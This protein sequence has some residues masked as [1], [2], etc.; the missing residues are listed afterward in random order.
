MLELLQSWKNW[1]E[2]TALN[3]IDPTMRV[4]PRSEMMRSIH[5]GLLCVQEHEANRPTMAQVV[6]L[7]SS[8][9][10]TLPVPSKPAF[11]MHSALRTEASLS[12]NERS[13]EDVQ[14]SRNEVSTSELYPR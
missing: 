14:Q 9:S 2:G 6:T 11:F 8:Y 7:L 13:N 1:N 12:T 4:A 10:I 3:L 5:I